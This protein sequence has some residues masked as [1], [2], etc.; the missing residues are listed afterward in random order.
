[1]EVRIWKN[2]K[3]VDFTGRNAI[4]ALAILFLEKEVRTGI[5]KKGQNYYIQVLHSKDGNVIGSVA[6][7]TE[8]EWEVIRA[9]SV[10]GRVK[11]EL[12]AERKRKRGR[13]IVG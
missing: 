8:E 5:I 4:T 9:L 6:Y 7:K 3:P 10:A 11:R 2:G 13:I 12:S 1:M